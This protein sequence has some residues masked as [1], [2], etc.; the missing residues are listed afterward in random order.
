MQKPFFMPFSRS[1]QAVL[2]NSANDNYAAA[3]PAK[4]QLVDR[5]RSFEAFEIRISVRSFAESINQVERWA[6][7]K[8]RT[9]LVTF[10][11]VH[12]LTEGYRS[13]TFH[14]IHGKMDLNCP[15]GMPLVWLGRLHGKQVTR[16]CGPEFMLAFCANAAHGSLRH[17]FYGGKD[18]IAE[19]LI[20]KLKIQN[21]L[22]QVAGYYAPPFRAISSE[23]D[24]LIVNQIND[25]GADIVWVSLGCPKQEIWIHEHRDKLH[26]PVL[27]AVGLAFDIIAGEKTRAPKFL[28][29][30]GLEWLYRLMQEPARLGNRYLKSNSLFLYMLFLSVFSRPKSYSR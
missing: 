28:R 26:A 8:T 9:R 23:E 1:S 13:P 20:D 14:M 17:F 15:D 5:R 16:V 30:V 12:M 18:G 6:S 25:S 3:S 22:L 19:R 27:I 11:N 21:P 4:L 24:T 10:T 2:R 7:E 29:D